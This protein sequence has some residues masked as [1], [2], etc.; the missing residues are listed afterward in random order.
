MCTIMYVDFLP[1]SR[2]PG[3]FKYQQKQ[4][5]KTPK[6]HLINTQNL[7]NIVL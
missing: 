2:H 1:A 5:Q 4:L 3:K 7:T 6:N